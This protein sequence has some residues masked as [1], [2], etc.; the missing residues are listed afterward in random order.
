M[1]TLV[2]IVTHKAKS[3]IIGSIASFFSLFFCH[4]THCIFQILCYILCHLVECRTLQGS[5]RLIITNQS[6]IKN[7]RYRT[8][9][10]QQIVHH[11]TTKQSSLT[12]E[13]LLLLY[14]EY[15]WGGVFNLVDYFCETRNVPYLLKMIRRNHSSTTCIFHILELRLTIIGEGSSPRT[16]APWGAF[17]RS[18]VKQSVQTTFSNVEIV[19]V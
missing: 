5:F 1:V 7:Y 2:Q 9:H 12:Q 11:K 17:I 6:W 19:H 15:G 16:Y 10:M 3:G 13:F 4:M 14:W 8:I 18:H